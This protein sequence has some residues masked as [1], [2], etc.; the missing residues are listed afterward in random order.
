MGVTIQLRRDITSN[1]QTVN[2]VLNE[3]E[4]GIEYNSDKSQ[5]L[6]IKI[7]NGSD[8]WNNLDYFLTSM[9]VGGS[10]DKRI[11]TLEVTSNIPH[12]TN[13]TLPNG[14]TYHNNNKSLEVYVNHLRMINGKDFTEID[15]SIISFTDIDLQTN[16]VVLFVAFK[17]VND[18]NEK[19]V[20]ADNDEFLISD[21][22][23]NYVNKKITVQE[24]KD[25]LMI[26]I[27]GGFSSSVYLNDQIFN[28]GGA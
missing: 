17:T 6:G 2:P 14:M 27:D 1:W 23:D 4:F 26:N 20:L 19:T 18:L 12:G 24:F 7:G 25:Y 16:D 13:I 22:E 10:V 5:I 11:E 8:T 28:G 15:D 21:S 9:S 3:G